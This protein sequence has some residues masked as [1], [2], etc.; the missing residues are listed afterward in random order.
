MRITKFT[1]TAVL[2][3]GATGIA[4]G[5]A[6]AAPAQPA[7]QPVHA[8][9]SNT[10]PMVHTTDHGVG[11]TSQFVAD[12]GFVT[13]LDSGTFALSADRKTVNVANAEGVVF[14]TLPTGVQVGEHRVM[15]A[16]TIDQ[17]GRKLVLSPIGVPADTVLKNINSQQWFFNE[18]QHAALGGI[19]GALVGGF[20]FPGIF[21]AFIPS[22]IIGG[23][24]GLLIAGGQP[25][26]DSGVAYFSGRP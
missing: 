16:P 19:I 7:P 26:V 24:V 8:Q 3:I 13:T 10:S 1:A 25:L 18:L 23:I 22:A 17:A 4:A 9:Q 21:L 6:Y 5:T 14:A 2:A 15:L 11:V 12:S 20:I